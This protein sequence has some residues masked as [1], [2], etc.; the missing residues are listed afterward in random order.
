M[1]TVG[2]TEHCTLPPHTCQTPES[3]S[4]RADGRSEGKARSIL[5]FTNKH[6][7]VP[8]TGTI[9]LSWDSER[10]LLPHIHS[11]QRSARAH[12]S[13]KEPIICT[14]LTVYNSQG[15]DP[16]SAG[17]CNPVKNLTNGTACSLLNS[18][19]ELDEHQ[20][21]DAPSIQAQ[22]AVLTGERQTGMTGNRGTAYKPQHCGN[23]ALGMGNY[24][25]NKN[26]ALGSV[27]REQKNP[28]VLPQM[29]SRL[30]TA[31]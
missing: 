24:A 11:P 25:T 27:I 1:E 3:C 16:S 7:F 19:E 14:V 30:D 22:K 15:Q 26:T 6:P 12:T 8:L 18:Q 13:D 5:S 28:V 4:R 29:Q 9:N 2:K 20:A 21:P 23:M 10:Q 17:S 31:R